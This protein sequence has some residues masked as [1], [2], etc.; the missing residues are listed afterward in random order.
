ME[1][2][3][4]SKFSF[5]LS[6]F[7]VY[8]SYIKDHRLFK[9]SILWT[10]CALSVLSY[11]NSH[12]CAQEVWDYSNFST[13]RGYNIGVRLIEDFLARTNTARCN[14]LRETADIIAKVFFHSVYYL[15]EFDFQDIRFSE[16]THIVSVVFFPFISTSNWVLISKT[17]LFRKLQI[18]LSGY[19]FPFILTS[20]RVLICKTYV[21]RS[22]S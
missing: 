6:L 10:V 1:R 21:F 4:V 14:D 9:L 12:F 15:T 22:L 3:L 5:T 20:N 8:D 16:T 18:Y 7:S 13:H 2:L 11:L 17:Y 19:F